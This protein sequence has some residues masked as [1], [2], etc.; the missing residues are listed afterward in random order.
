MIEKGVI[1]TVSGD[2]KT[3]TAVPSFSD[4]PV[5][6]TLTVPFFLAG[7]LTVGMPVVYAQFEDNTGVVLA[8]MDGDWNHALAGDV[9]IKG[10][11]TA[12]D[13]ITGAVSSYNGHTHTGP[14]GET[15]GPK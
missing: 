15:S 11:I 1:S 3:V 14:D 12:Q 10:N 5:S 9:E 2:G 6:P 4:A 8:R 7:S 13:M